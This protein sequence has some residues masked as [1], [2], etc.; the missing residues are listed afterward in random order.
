MRWKCTRK[1][2]VTA[3]FNLLGAAACLLSWEAV[4]LISQMRAL[5]VPKPLVGS[6]GDRAGVETGLLDHG[7]QLPNLFLSLFAGK[8]VHHH[9]SHTSPPW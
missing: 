8:K 4:A 9:P 2:M 5:R 3:T 1:T 7:V 6:K